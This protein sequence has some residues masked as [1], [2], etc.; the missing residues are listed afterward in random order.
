MKQ[1]TTGSII[2]F[3]KEKNRIQ[4][5]KNPNYWKKE[6]AER[7]VEDY[8]K[9]FGNIM[10]RHGFDLA[11]EWLYDQ[12]RVLAGLTTYEEIPG[13]PPGTYGDEEYDLD[14]SYN[15]EWVQESELT[16][17]ELLDKTRKENDDEWTG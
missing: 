15:S 12:L 11:F 3:K 17:Q 1:Q 9:Q 14:N 16:V 2:N 6:L 8:K 13:D 10:E 7:T 5:S 4:Y